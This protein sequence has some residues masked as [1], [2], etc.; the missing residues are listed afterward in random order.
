MNWQATIIKHNDDGLTM[1]VR[2]AREGYEPIVVGVMLP[3]VGADLQQHVAQY[4]PLS[5][6]HWI[7]QTMVDRF[8]PA[9]GTVIAAPPVASSA[10]APAPVPTIELEPVQ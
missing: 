8:A 4:A 2:Y 10:P 6:W 3:P 7:D 9:V 1:D 5:T